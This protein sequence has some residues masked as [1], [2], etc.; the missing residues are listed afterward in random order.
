MPGRNGPA[1]PVQPQ[2]IVDVLKKKIPSIKAALLIQSKVSGSAEADRESSSFL[3]FSFGHLPDLLLCPCFGIVYSI[4]FPDIFVRAKCFDQ[5]GFVFTV[6]PYCL[7]CT[8]SDRI[9]VCCPAKSH[10]L[11]PFRRRMGLENRSHCIVHRS[12]AN[13]P[14]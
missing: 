1:Y 13:T 14:Y 11:R 4:S 9:L 12:L 8:V 3:L 10:R 5:K 2:F 7:N 6:N